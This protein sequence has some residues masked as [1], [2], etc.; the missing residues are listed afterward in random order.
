MTSNQARPLISLNMSFAFTLPQTFIHLL[1]D[2][3]L[4]KYFHV[5][6]LA[7]MVYDYLLTLPDEIQYIWTAR[8]TSSGGMTLYLLTRYLNFFDATILT[9][10]LFDRRLSTQPNTCSSVYQA[11]AWFELVGI[12]VA[13]VI[14]FLRTYAI[15]GQSRKILYFIIF[16]TLLMIPCAVVIKKDISTLEFSPSPFPNIIPCVPGGRKSILYI[17]YVLVLGVEFVIILLTAWIGIKQ[18]KGETK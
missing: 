14:L 16:S 13:E 7:L 2:V 1:D 11:T 5:A 15:W 17:D 6:S 18:C 8:R 12:T 4:V 10:F 9:I 3:L